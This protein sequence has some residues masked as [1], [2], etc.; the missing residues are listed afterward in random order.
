MLYLGIDLHGKQM[1]VCGRDENGD[2]LLRR[3]VSTRPGKV[4]EFFEELRELS[5]AGYV[6]ILEICGFHD[7]LVLRLKQQ[8]ACH[9]VLLVRPEGRSKK[10]TDRRD[11]DK[12]SEMLWVNRGRLLAGA[13]A[14]G[15]RRVYFPT[16]DERQDRQLTA[17]RL[18]LGRRR[19]QTIN[20]MRHLLRRNNLE[21]D[22]PTKS[23]QTQKVERWLRTL[24]FDAT[25][26]LEMDHLLAQWE[27]WR[28]QINALE[29]RLAQ[30]FQQNRAA[31]WLATIRGVSGYMGLA[32][33]SRIGDIGRFPHGRSLANFFGLT[34]GSRSS[35]E[36]ERLGSITKEGSR[37]VRFLLGQLVLHVLRTDARMRTWFQRIKQRRGAKIARVAVMRRLAVII[38]HMLTKQQAYVYG[39]M[40]QRTRP[41]L[42]EHP[43]VEPAE[44]LT[45]FGLKLPQAAESEPSTGS[46]SL[47]PVSSEVPSC[48]A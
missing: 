10:K 47:C 36:T 21:W 33:A 15:V 30:R 42:G 19:T 31:Q 34:P 13:K 41:G 37:V 5:D 11:A 48:P 16:L 29:E 9:D 20:Q 27:L 4:S 32:I 6:A 45:E 12:L 7:W 8:E 14:Q 3:Q 26:R 18:R 1:T 43:P 35:G 28:R 24:S 2:R 38:W 46:S 40:P 39:G 25:D 44:R 17:V 23:F 22:R